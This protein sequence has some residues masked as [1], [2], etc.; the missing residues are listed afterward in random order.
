MSI[1]RVAAAAIVNPHNQVF[2]SRRQASQHLAGKWE[3]PGGKIEPG[4]TSEEALARELW[5]EL[6]IHISSCRPLISVTHTH[7][8]RTLCIDFWRVDTFEG[9]PFGREGQVTAWVGIDELSN[10][11]FPEANLPVLRALHLPD[12]LLITPEVRLPNTETFLKTLE[13]SIVRHSLSMIQ[14]RAPSLP[15]ADYCALAEDVLALCQQHRVRLLVNADPR[16]LDQV[17]AHGC[18]L[19]SYRLKIFSQRPFSEDFLLSAACH[20]GAELTQAGLIDADF[21]LISPVMLTASHPALKNSLS[22]NGFSDMAKRANRPAYALGGM[23]L[24]DRPSVWASGGQ[25]IAAIRGLWEE[26]KRD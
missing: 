19:N 7:E 8:N 11:A 17:G 9:V 4:E 10:Y 6:G 16:V 23:G 3:F 2:I 5:E 1:L 26:G 24:E 20:N 14:L 12:R 25:G 22:W 15:E 18:H 21:V 13:R